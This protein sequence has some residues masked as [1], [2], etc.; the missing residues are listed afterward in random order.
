M[1]NTLIPVA[2]A[3]WNQRLAQMIWE[4][5]T[6]VL[7]LCASCTLQ[8]QY[9]MQD[10]GFMTENRFTMENGLRLIERENNDLNIQSA[11]TIEYD[12]AVEVSLT[13]GQTA[14]YR[15]DFSTL[16]DSYISL[17]YFSA[18][19]FGYPRNISR[20]MGDEELQD[21]FGI[22][23]YVNQ[24]E[25][26]SPEV[27]EEGYLSDIIYYTNGYEPLNGTLYIEPYFRTN[28]TLFGSTDLVRY[29]LAVSRDSP[30]FQW[31]NISLAGIVDTDDDSVFLQSVTYNVTNSTLD[32]L[33]NS[34]DGIKLQVFDDE[35][36][37]DVSGLLRSFGA[38]TTAQTV[39]NRTDVDIMNRSI[40]GA[41][42]LQMFVKG[43]EAD[44]DYHA[45]ITYQL[46][47]TSVVGAAL[48]FTTQEAGACELIY[49]LEFCSD[50]AYSVPQSEAF[51]QNGDNRD[52]K[53][54]YDALPAAVYKN[55]SLAMQQI[56]CD[57]DLE[58]RFSPIA[59]CED[60]V[61]S[62]KR[63]L[64]AVTIPRCTTNTSSYFQERE[65]YSMRTDELAS[66]INP[67]NS[68]HE[69]LPCIDMCHAMVRDCPSDFS[70]ACPGNSTMVMM[71]YNYFVEDQGYDTCNY[72]GTIP[73]TVAVVDSAGPIVTIDKRLLILCVLPLLL[74]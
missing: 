12:V 10:M 27:F 9:V 57:A 61:A 21:I 47:A 41:I 20:N 50:V 17:I 46:N 22:N 8:G 32:V 11:E 19:V 3:V 67:P 68:Y 49:N 28:N 35:T 23:L 34:T 44:T 13:P 25:M 5:S 58:S 16:P 72:L 33:R 54:L 7:A 38:I 40:N 26:A 74:L 43:L 42:R 31:D 14:L 1:F 71:S 69:V 39:I 63:W 53:I 37:D 29:S 24:T 64:C 4:L 51:T 52:L 73:S 59:T 66:R 18:N 70:F 36:F 15:F 48:N 65:A 60:C 55:F 6:L 62:Y 2:A 30:V 56:A 45:I